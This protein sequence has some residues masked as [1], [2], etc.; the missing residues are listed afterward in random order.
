MNPAPNRYNQFSYSDVNTERRTERVDDKQYEPRK[1]FVQK[2]FYDKKQV[3]ST[4]TKESYGSQISGTLSQPRL[5]RTNEAPIYAG[6]YGVYQ[7][8]AMM[9]QGKGY[10]EHKEEEIKKKKTDRVEPKQQNE[11]KYGSP[12]KFEPEEQEEEPTE[13]ETNEPDETEVDEF[14]RRSSD[15]SSDSSSHTSS[16]AQEDTSVLKEEYLPDGSGEFRE[17]TPENMEE[18]AEL[19]RISLRKAVVRR[20]MQYGL[21]ERED[22]K[23]DTETEEKYSRT[24]SRGLL[25]ECDRIPST[26][27]EEHGRSSNCNR[28]DDEDDD[29]RNVHDDDDD[30]N[31]NDDDDDEN[32]EYND[33]I[34]DNDGGNGSDQDIDETTNAATAEDV[35]NAM[36]GSSDDDSTIKGSASADEDVEDNGARN[37]EE[38]ED[39]EDDEERNAEDEEDLGMKEIENDVYLSEDEEDGEGW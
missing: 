29:D 38:D 1:H 21:D 37:I 12:E 11:E 18:L 10:D 6:V 20:Q 35:D 7:N 2:K 28:N 13:I 39:V 24:T 16:D 8:S 4:K 36:H 32:N 33:D 9:K 23:D 34:N 17:N 22:T 5:Q 27:S 31:R 3:P 30:Y 25:E 19:E 26:I 14:E 15:S